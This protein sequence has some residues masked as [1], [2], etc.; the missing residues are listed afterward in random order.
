MRAAVVKE[1][2][3]I[4]SHQMGVLPDPIR[5]PGEVVVTVKAVGARK[6]AES[7]DVMAR[8][9]VVDARA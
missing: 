9:M 6:T 2:G 7:A 8:P 3:P 4:A 1:F 5:G